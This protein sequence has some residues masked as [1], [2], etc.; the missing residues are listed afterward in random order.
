MKKITVCIWILLAGWIFGACEDFIDLQPKDRIGMNDYWKTADDL[1]NYTLQFYPVF[2]PNTAMV[3]ETAVDSDDLFFGSPSSVLNGMR[4]KSTG[5]WQGEWTSIRNVNIFFENYRRCESPF[6]SYRQ[7]LGEAHF[8]RAWFYFNLLKKYGDL[9][10]YSGVL[11]LDSEDELMRPRDP[12]TLVADSILADLDN[13][14]LCLHS[15]AQTGNCRIS[16]EAALAFKSRVAL[17]EGTW[18]KYHAGTEFG[19]PGADP[20]TYFRQCV[21]AAEEL[22]NGDY[23]TGIY[24]TG[25]PDEDYFKLFGFDN[26]SNIDEVLLY[27]AFNAADGFGNTVQGYITYNNDSKAV[28]WDLIS[29]YLGLDGKPYDYSGVSQTAKGNDF[30]TGIAADCDPRLK[31]TVWIPGDRMSAVTGAYF[32]KPPIDQ[33]SLQLCQTGF[34]PKKT[35]NPNAPNAGQS[36]EVRGETGFIILRYGEVLLNYAE[37]RYE[38]DRTVAYDQLNL[39]RSR[40]G[41]PAFTVHPKHADSNRQDYGYEI[42]DALYE[43]RRERRVE[44]ALEGYRDEDL[45]RWAAHSLFQNKRPA[46]Y[47]FNQSEF[48]E[49]HPPLDADGRIDYWVNTL[50]EGYRFREKQDYLY[51][52]PQDEL[53]LNPNL[54]QNPGW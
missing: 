4:A 27:K 34:M 20:D 10:W 11:Q 2:M 46:G 35:A 5:N 49:F 28:T 41:M 51:S 36:W 33:G 18:Q 14:V 43:I 25:N 26:M 54:K 47:P 45:M 39:L 15:R 7:Y 32:T 21:S 30:L 40:A 22:M 31:S 37:A 44:M 48:P 24:A 29:S 50:P 38:L 17:Y 3:S 52:I 23:K 19:T 42:S 9:P 6:D 8:F 53:T 16:K 13:A 1:G 12:R